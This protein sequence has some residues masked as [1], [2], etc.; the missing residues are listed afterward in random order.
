M[1]NEKSNTENKEWSFKG[2]VQ[3]VKKNHL[4]YYSDW[5]LKND[6]P[7]IFQEYGCKK[8]NTLPNMGKCGQEHQ[9]NSGQTEWLGTKIL[10]CNTGL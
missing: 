4:I 2:N 5:I 9:K 6:L 1:S 3:Q 8:Q 10:C 7:I